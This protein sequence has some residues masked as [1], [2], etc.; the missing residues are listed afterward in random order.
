[1]IS[2]PVENESLCCTV[3]LPFG[4]ILAKVQPCF[5]ST[6]SWKWTTKVGDRNRVVTFQK[7]EFQFEFFGHFDHTGHLALT[8]LPAAQLTRFPPEK[9]KITKKKFSKIR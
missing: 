8:I 4:I 3:V 5:A 9:L 7:F 2:N 1:L 6:I